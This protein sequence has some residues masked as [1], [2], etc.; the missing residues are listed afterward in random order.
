MSVLFVLCEVEVFD[1][2][3]TGATRTSARSVPLQQRRRVNKAGSKAGRTCSDV[4]VAMTVVRCVYFG[5]S[6]GSVNH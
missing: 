2:T 3:R 5:R 1:G 6:Q 4:I